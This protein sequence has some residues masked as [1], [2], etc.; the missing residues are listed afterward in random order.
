MQPPGGTYDTGLSTQVSTENTQ[1]HQQEPAI[2]D[3]DQGQVDIEPRQ[4]MQPP[5]G[6]HDTGLGTQASTQS[7][8][9]LG[10]L[11]STQNTNTG[12]GSQNNNNHSGTQNIQYGVGQVSG[13]EVN[14]HFSTKG[15]KGL[16]RLSDAIA[17]VGASHKAEHQFS[18]GECLE[19]TRKSARTA[20]HNWASAKG[21][22][23][24]PICWLSGAA[25]VGKSAIA[26]TIAKAFEAAAILT[27]SFFFFRS[28]PRRNNPTS[29]ILTIAHGLAT[30]IPLMRDHIEQR[31]S[32]DPTILEASLEE[33]FRELV[34]LPAVTW[35]ID[36]SQRD[37][38][39]IP[40]IIIIDGL[41]ECGDEE[42][43]LRILSI[44]Q[45]AYQQ[46]P[47][48]PLRFLICSRPEAWIQEAFSDESLSRLS[49]NFTLDN[50]L[51]AREDVR[52]YYIRHFH[53]ITTS[54][55]Y[56]QV[57][58]PSP[59]P[60]VQD[61]DTLVERSCAQFVY[62]T[63][64]VKFIKLAGGHP[65]IQLR[66]ILQSTV[67]V[68]PSRSPYRDL[69]CLYQVILSANPIQDELILILVAIL[70]FPEH[71]ADP[72][73]AVIEAVLGLPSGQ[74][75][76]TLRGMYSV[77]EIG[78]WKEHIRLYHTSFREYLLDYMRSGIDIA[79]QKNI[80]AGRWL[81]SLSIDR[82][83]GLSNGQFYN[84]SYF[85]P[86]GWMTLCKSLAQPTLDLLKNLL[87][88]DLGVEP[89]HKIMYRIAE[90]ATGCSHILGLGTGTIDWG[91]QPVLL[92]E[93]HCDLSGE[94]ESHNPQ[95]NAYQDA[96]MEYAKALTSKFAEMIAQGDREEEGSGIELVEI[97]CNLV[98]SAL[99]KHCC[100]GTEL[101]LLCQNFFKVVKGYP[102]IFNFV[103]EY[104]EK[105]PWKGN[106]LGKEKAN[107]L[108]W[109]E[110]QETPNPRTTTILVSQN[111]QIEFIYEPEP[112]RPREYFYPTQFTRPD[113]TTNLRLKSFVS[114]TVLEDPQYLHNKWLRLHHAIWW[115]EA[116][117]YDTH[118]SKYILI[119]IVYNLEEDCTKIHVLKKVPITQLHV[120]DQN[121]VYG[122]VVAEDDFPW[123][124][125]HLENYNTHI[126]IA[127]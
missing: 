47:H 89:Q 46:T 44:I 54:Q 88:V 40:S 82:L 71:E 76:L 55:K 7:T 101:F 53:E 86:M 98:V 43:Q 45:S 6:T 37:A 127:Y 50:S 62:A 91:Q 67:K 118:H 16:K 83:Q 68:Q 81:Q 12:L 28:D 39:V 56:R 78:G 48:L 70:I 103:Q 18:R 1:P 8:H 63:T 58:F 20:I 29:L 4:G 15:S 87:S 113:E 51:E 2:D 11:V 32:T 65:I 90:Y 85:R 38:P 60:S 52:R 59:W 122:R 3:V 95:H 120:T 107:L 74:V 19:G 110:D 26:L 57:Q 114:K 126:Y 17:G 34:T 69:D 24:L 66:L 125:N 27:S 73:P 64:L 117:M 72:T 9:T 102:P 23:A 30:T 109:I 119:Q 5:Q 99:V 106:L 21:P 35:S 92:S 105:N 36:G 41:D 115:N 96:C 13:R 42:T 100:L 14:L 124:T 25:G 61:L 123:Q 31:I 97:F 104:A 80:I 33:Q 94:Q 84:E 77:L 112:L 79:A 75:D 22:E 10:T 93:C 121:L 116:P 111:L 108:E 49:R